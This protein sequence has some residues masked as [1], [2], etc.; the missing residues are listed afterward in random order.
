MLYPDDKNKSLVILFLDNMLLKNYIFFW[1]QKLLVLLC[2]YK[3][4]M[5]LRQKQ[6]LSMLSLHRTCLTCLSCVHYSLTRKLDYQRKRKRKV[7]FQIFLSGCLSLHWQLK[8]T[9]KENKGT[10]PLLRSASFYIIIDSVPFMDLLYL[11]P[12]QVELQRYLLVETELIFISS[13]SLS[14]RTIFVKNRMQWSGHI[15]N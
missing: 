5:G 3:L 8:Y 10:E 4:S 1:Q 6:K 9:I 7:H 14:L 11:P 13:P 2:L 15:I 12:H